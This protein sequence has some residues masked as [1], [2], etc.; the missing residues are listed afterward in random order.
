M[1][2]WCRRSSDTVQHVLGL[3]IEAHR[4]VG[5]VSSNGVAIVRV[6]AGV[7]DA[8]SLGI[9]N[10]GHCL[11][12]DG[13]NF[14]KSKHAHLPWAVRPALPLLVAHPRRSEMG[15]DGS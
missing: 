11:L 2:K 6:A 5:K 13:Y 14:D 10:D 3:R 12:R 15:W 8:I 9:V 1:S 7:D 4:A